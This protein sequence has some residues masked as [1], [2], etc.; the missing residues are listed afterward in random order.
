MLLQAVPARVM[1]GVQAAVGLHMSQLDQGQQHDAAE[2]LEVDC[3]LLPDFIL[4]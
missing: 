1:R 2:A 4:A 3:W